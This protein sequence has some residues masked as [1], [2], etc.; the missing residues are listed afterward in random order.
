MIIHQA[1]GEVQVRNA[2]GVIGLTTHP[3]TQPQMIQTTGFGAIS[4][5]GGLTIGYFNADAALLP[6][7]DCR[8][9]VWLDENQP[10]EVVDKLKALGDSLCSVGP[11]ARRGR[12]KQ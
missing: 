1:D 8:I 6:T 4:R 7:G 5:D 11:G 9:V 12:N 10:H 2:A 3:G